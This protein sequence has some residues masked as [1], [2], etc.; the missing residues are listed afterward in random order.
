MKNLQKRRPGGPASWRMAAGLLVLALAVNMAQWA[1]IAALEASRREDAA[2]YQ[3]Q[4]ESAERM[5]DRAVEQL[6]AAVLQAEADRQARAEQ[7]AAYEAVGAYRYIG[8]CTITAYCPC[9]ECC[10]R[11]ADGV[12]ATGLPAG[13][14]VVAVDPEVIPL[15]S[16]VIIDGQ[17]YLAADTGVTGNHV[18]ICLADHA[19]T[20]AFGVKTAEVWV[21]VMEK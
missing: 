15:G 10:G 21:E 9:E 20:A 14:G 11:W 6:G 4:V 17:R 18:D 1:R 3:A 5:R 8:E 2:R 12:T 16:T 7:A 19:E 13:P